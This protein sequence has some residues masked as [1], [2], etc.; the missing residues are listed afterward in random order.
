MKTITT[1]ILTTF[2]LCSL[3]AAASSFAAADQDEVNNDRYRLEIILFQMLEG[4]V[5]GR[6]RTNLSHYA[7]LTEQ[8]KALIIGNEQIPAPD[9]LVEEIQP[10]AQ[11]EVMANA[12]KRLRGS[13]EFRPLI[14]Q[15]WQEQRADTVSRAV[16]GGVIGT[17]TR[18]HND[19]V[20]FTPPNK[21]DKDMEYNSEYISADNV[22]QSVYQLDG[23]ATFTQGRFLHISLDFEFRQL[24]VKPEA[25]DGIE[26]PNSYMVF[27][28]KKSRQI[29][30][31]R[32]EFF[33]NEKFGA[34]IYLEEINQAEEPSEDTVDAES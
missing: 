30:P 25:T 27:S 5:A 7:E 13:R 9:K 10:L 17:A 4:N 34:L 3:V 32:L 6:F 2:I 1:F 24:L 15:Q 11:S 8:S 20:L 18:V 21:P 33:D 23:M 29:R 16:P 12:W 26:S 31:Q 22:D 14:Y 28:L 19:I